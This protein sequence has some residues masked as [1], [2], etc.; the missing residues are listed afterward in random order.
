MFLLQLRI[1]TVTQGLS[2][3]TWQKRKTCGVMVDQR[4]WRV[5]CFLKHVNP[6]FHECINERW[7]FGPGPCYSYFS[8]H[9]EIPFY[10]NGAGVVLTL[11]GL[12]IVWPA[13]PALES[14]TQTQNMELLWCKRK[15]RTSM[16][17]L[18]SGHRFILVVVTWGYSFIWIRN[19]EKAWSKDGLC[20]L[21]AN[22][23]NL[24]SDLY[25]RTL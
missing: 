11:W 14:L 17:D 2:E 18:G 10:H 5:V 1:H 25:Q 20:L 22:Q 6:W 16:E 19:K 15:L 9:C 4:H 13:V 23:T 7:A 8:G 21:E 12:S 3:F 24:K